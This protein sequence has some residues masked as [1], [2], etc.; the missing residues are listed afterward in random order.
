MRLR[1]LTHTMPGQLLPVANQPMLFYALRSLQDA[2]ITDVALVVGDNHHQVER[3]VGRGSAFGLSVTYVRQSEPLGLAHAIMV[4]R[5]FLGSDDFVMLVGGHVIPGGITDLVRS[6]ATR[7]PDAMVLVGK[8]ADTTH[9]GVVELG[10]D[11]SVTRLEDRPRSLRSDLALIGA[12]VFSP[13]IH[14][15]VL[16]IRPNW[17]REWTITEALQWL[18]DRDLDVQAQVLEGYWQDTGELSG[19]LECNRSILSSLV[20][21]V[22][23]DVDEESTLDGAVV[24]EDG[25]VIQRSHLI[26]PVVIGS[27]SIVVDSV[28]GPF[29]AIG[30]E[31]V[32]EGVRVEDSVVL[33][34]AR[35]TTSARIRGSLIGR[36][37]LVGDAPEAGHR[38]VVAD[39]SRVLLTP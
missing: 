17:R 36:Q 4:A 5:D 25:A 22:R 3:A 21:D 29:T 34:G 30:A 28:V 7:R 11:A 24:V 10:A 39:H 26:G 27:E 37:A 16:G 6:F 23:G 9:H 1:P 31:C 13:A 14:Q 12:Y 20:T 38:L 15:A 35:L 2:G 33:P 32:L 8:V 19:V 18:V